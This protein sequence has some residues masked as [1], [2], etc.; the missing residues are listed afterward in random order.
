DSRQA[1]W[2]D[3]A[4][5]AFQSPIFPTEHLVELRVKSSLTGPAPVAVVFNNGFNAF[6]GVSFG[7]QY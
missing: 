4:R 5:I 3:E 2:A 1:L 7:L 6:I